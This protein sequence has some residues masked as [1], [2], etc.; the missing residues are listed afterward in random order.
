MASAVTARNIPSNMSAPYGK[1]EN[2]RR[3]TTG[4]TSMKSQGTAMTP[5]H[6][7]AKSFRVACSIAV[8]IFS[9]GLVLPYRF[10]VR[11]VQVELGAVLGDADSD[12]PLASGAVGDSRSAIRRQ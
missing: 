7:A 2:H 9:I 11:V 8:S 6:V 1:P 4:L 12:Q 5:Q 3:L 10:A